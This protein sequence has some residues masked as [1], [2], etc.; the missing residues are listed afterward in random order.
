MDELTMN[1]TSERVDDRYLKILI[2]GEAAITKMLRKLLAVLDS[3]QVAFEI[4]PDA[5][6]ERDA[7]F[8]V[9]KEFLHGVT[10]D[11][12]PACRESFRT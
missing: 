2:V 3:L 7:V 8:H 12:N 1:L 11:T 5:I 6:S 4:D 10:S 9:E